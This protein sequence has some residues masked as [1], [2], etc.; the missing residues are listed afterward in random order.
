MSDKVITDVPEYL[1]QD[2]LPFPDTVEDVNTIG[3][4]VDGLVDEGYY[5]NH[6]SRAAR[7][8]G[9]F[10]SQSHTVEISNTFLL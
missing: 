3:H 6:D 8:K 5:T 1:T 4:Q 2:T 10:R 9:T 7:N